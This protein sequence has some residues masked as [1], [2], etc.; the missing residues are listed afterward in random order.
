M[1][2]ERT[3]EEMEL[4]Q[5]ANAVYRFYFALSG[6]RE[7]A[8]IAT[9]ALLQ[10]CASREILTQPL[11]A[12]R[13]GISR[14]R[15]RV[16]KPYSPYNTDQRIALSLRFGAGLTN[17]EV[18]KV[19]GKS[20]KAVWKLALEAVDIFNKQILSGKKIEG[21]G[22]LIAPEI[23]QVESIPPQARRKFIERKV[24]TS[25]VIQDQ[26]RGL[27]F[28]IKVVGVHVDCVS[29]DISKTSTDLD[30]ESEMNHFDFAKGGKYNIAGSEIYLTAATTDRR[31]TRPRSTFAVF[32][33]QEFLIRKEQKVDP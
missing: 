32:A 8:A 22:R 12:L 9:D 29:T 15:Q 31:Y 25:L 10:E 4:E 23:V 13:L 28:R 19:M 18:A 6:N 27:G 11:K 1:S 5:T 26:E 3:A 7:D 21:E 17:E 14:F 30:E 20:R 33:P 16:E 24:G 2:I